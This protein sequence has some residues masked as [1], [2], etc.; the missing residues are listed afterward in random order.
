M[1]LGFGL[2][3]GQR[4]PD[5]PRSWEDVY[6]ELIELTVHLERRGYTSVW[7][8]EHHFVDDGYMPSL[9]VTSAAMAAVTSRIQIGTGVVLAPLH[10]P[11][12]LAEDAATVELISQ[13]RLLLGLGLGWSE[14]EYA[15]FGVDITKRGSAMSE[16]LQFL[17]KAWTGEP[18]TWD[19]DLYSYPELAV[20][21]APSGP[22]PLIVGGSVD[23]AAR[24]AARYADGFFSNA[25]PE[26]FIA[27]V[28]AA[29][30]EMERIGRDPSSFRWIHYSVMYPGHRDE[31]IDQ[32][33]HQIWKY[34]DMEDSTTRGGPI[35]RTAPLSDDMAERVR[36]RILG[37]SPEEIVHTIGTLRDRVGVPVEW[38]ARSHFS[39]LHYGQQVELVDRLAQEVG[40]HLPAD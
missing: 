8:T 37:G 25:S 39:D 29:T 1:N 18:F 5:D 19:G 40:P 14:T 10:N 36:S 15:I 16:I 31:I 28:A 24:R 26:R 2:L 32:V 17:P 3:S 4:A 33:W 9:L 13:G 12:R 34:T 21:P 30:E 38:V 22:I 7:T 23:A 20:R 27:Q 11:I 35:A 6:R